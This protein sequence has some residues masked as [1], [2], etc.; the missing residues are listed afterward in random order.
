MAIAF[1]ALYV[2]ALFVIWSIVAVGK[3]SDERLDKFLRRG[4]HDEKTTH[5]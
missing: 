1:V 3:A 2:C 4:R 5:P